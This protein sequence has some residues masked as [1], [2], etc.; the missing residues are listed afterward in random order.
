MTQHRAA[1]LLGSNIEPARHLPA[2]LSALHALGRVLAVSRVWQSPS[3]GDRTQPDYCNVA[4]L[5]ETSYSPEE[6]LASHSPLR[7]MESQLGRVRDPG[8]KFAARTIDLDLC[9]YD[10]TSLTS[11][12]KVLPN[13]DLFERSCAAVPLAELP[14]VQLPETCDLSL[15]DL[16]SQLLQQ[17]PLTPR[18]DIDAAITAVLSSSARQTDDIT[19]GAGNV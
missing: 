12:G 3:I 1:L 8:N 16:A 2:A 4:V 14:G 7:R 10:R 6:L 9:L 11:S 18:P 5:W 17:Q 15:T 19:Q 13:P